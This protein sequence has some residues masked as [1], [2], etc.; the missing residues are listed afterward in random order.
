[1]ESNANPKKHAQMKGQGG[2]RPGKV[3]A[4]DENAGEKKI[5]ETELDSA[6]KALDR[7]HGTI[8]SAR[9]EIARIRE[10]R[11]AKQ[12]EYR[13]ATSE[14]RRV[15]RAEQIKFA[16]LSALAR[17]AERG[18]LTAETLAARVKAL[19]TYVPFVPEMEQARLLATLISH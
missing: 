13:Q 4:R 12:R 6:Q 14:I 5:R 16:E 8:D 7:L 3:V 18:T 19:E 1:V 2:R 11:D 10:K 17:N 15:L 9:Q